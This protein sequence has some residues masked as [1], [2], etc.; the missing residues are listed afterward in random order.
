MQWTKGLHE[1]GLHN[2]LKQMQESLPSKIAIVRYTCT[3]KGS[4]LMVMSEKA[5]PVSRGMELMDV[6]T[7]ACKKEGGH[8][9]GKRRMA[10]TPEKTL[11]V[12]RAEA[13]LQQSDCNVYIV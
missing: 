5:L 4:E 3:S 1:C 8:M 11:S 6:C 9:I 12:R 13:A 2:I 10:Y 7:C